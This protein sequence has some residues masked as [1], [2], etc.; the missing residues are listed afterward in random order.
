MNAAEVV[1]HVV[2]RNR[3]A[4]IVH[5]L[6]EAV[7]E[8]GKSAHV[9]PHRQVLAFHVAGAHMLW[10]RVPTHDLHIAADARAGE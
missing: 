8:S 2:Q 6:A 9:H 5:F 10:V 4:V 1:E 7:C 3:M